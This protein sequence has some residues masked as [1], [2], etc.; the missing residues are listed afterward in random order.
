ML[1]A[2][3]LNRSGGAIAVGMPVTGMPTVSRAFFIDL[4]LGEFYGQ[5]A[6]PST[7]SLPVNNYHLSLKITGP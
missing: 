3:I 1:A 2:S 4:P 7:G 5:V 6:G